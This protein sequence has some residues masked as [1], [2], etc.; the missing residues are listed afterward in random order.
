[1]HRADDGML[2]FVDR[3]K[4]MI[5][6]AGENIAAAEVEAVLQA[7]PEVAQVAVLGCPDE[8]RETE[9]LA[10]I[11][12]KAGQR[13]DQALAEHLHAWAADRLAYYKA[14]GWIIFLTQLPTTGTQKIQKHQIFSK[15]EDPR[16]RSGIFDL[17]PLKKRR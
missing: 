12:P 5:R 3:S 2:Y 8:T 4:N 1:V 16:T 9:V 17:R 6:R 14:P 7:A 13:P 11:V 15:G 10:C